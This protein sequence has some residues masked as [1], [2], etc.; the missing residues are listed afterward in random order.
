[1]RVARADISLNGFTNV[2]ITGRS[3]LKTCWFRVETRH[4]KSDLEEYGLD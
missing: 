2:V 1:M 4:G 3:V